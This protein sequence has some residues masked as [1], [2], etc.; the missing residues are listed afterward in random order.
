MIKELESASACVLPPKK[1][2]YS[3]LYYSIKLTEMIYF[4]IP[5]ISTRLDTYLYYYPE[6][7]ILYF[8]SGDID[9]LANKIIYA[10]ENKD[11]LDN[12]TTNAWHYYQNISWDKM[13]ERYLLLVKDMMT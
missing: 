2:I 6:N 13:K 3:D 8:N 10:W 4:R 12:F 5:V 7:C 9:D 1:D 11:K